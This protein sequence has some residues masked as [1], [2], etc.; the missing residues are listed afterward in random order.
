MATGC[1]AHPTFQL[2]GLLKSHSFAPAPASRHSPSWLGPGLD[3]VELPG[4]DAALHILC[5]AHLRLQG[6]AHAQQPPG[7]L[8]PGLLGACK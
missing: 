2:M 1:A 3:D 7:E 6:G 8:R 4:C 5:T